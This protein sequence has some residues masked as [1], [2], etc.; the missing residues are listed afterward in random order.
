MRNRHQRIKTADSNPLY[1]KIADDID[2]K[3][4][5]EVV[6]SHYDGGSAHEIKSALRIRT[7][8]IA[9]G[10][11]MDELMFSKFFINYLGLDYM[12]W[13][14][15]ITTASTYLPD[16]RNQI[17]N[18][19]LEKTEASHLLMLDSDVLPPPRLIERL[20]LHDKDM[21]GGFYRKKERFG[22][23]NKDGRVEI[24]QRPVVYDFLRVDENGVPLYTQRIQTGKG[25]EKVGG[26]GAGLWLMSRKVAEALGK[27]PYSMAQGAGEDLLICHKIRQ[28]GFD[29]WIDWDI[30]AAHAGVFFV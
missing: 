27:S 8:Q 25:M 10:L 6:H 11:P 4:P 18:V 2:D 28:L 15:I 23:K 12:P 17:H 3:I 5:D 20:M 29:L 24:T 19:F 26:A 30:Q 1:E 16:A 21:V 13:D 14:A 7:Q 22:F 9:I